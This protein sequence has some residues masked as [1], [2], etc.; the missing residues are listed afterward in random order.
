MDNLILGVVGIGW[1]ATLVLLLVGFRTSSS[2]RGTAVLT[3][4]IIIGILVI[5]LCGLFVCLLEGVVVGA[6]TWGAAMVLYV[7]SVGVYVICIFSPIEA[8]VTIKLL[9]D[10]ATAPSGGIEKKDLLR[11]YNV[12]TIIHLRIQRLLASHTIAKKDGRYVLVKEVSIFM[13]REYITAIILFLFPKS[14]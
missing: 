1:L 8:S 12:D 7:L 5:A 10:I 11:G 2:F 13:L 14:R 9:T 4:S 6:V 3:R